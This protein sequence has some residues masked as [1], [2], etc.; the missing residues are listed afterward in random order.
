[1][2]L[3][4]PR[5]CRRRAAMPARAGARTYQ[6]W[7][8]GVDW[9]GAT[10]RTVL[11]RQPLEHTELG[12]PTCASAAPTSTGSTG[13]S[14]G[15]ISVVEGSMG[16]QREANAEPHHLRLVDGRL[17]RPDAREPRGGEHVDADARGGPRPGGAAG[18]EDHHR[19]AA[20]APARATR[21]EGQA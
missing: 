17:H 6:G 12:S 7:P 3:V 9:G 4:A 5:P 13:C 19:A 20:V 16:S 21:Q 11:S 10:P 1:V 18:E 2:A 8:P 14:E 15:G